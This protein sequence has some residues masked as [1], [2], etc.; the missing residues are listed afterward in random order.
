MP[1]NR[2]IIHL[3][4]IGIKHGTSRSRI[5]IVPLLCILLLVCFCCI[6]SNQLLFPP[7]PPS[8]PSNDQIVGGLNRFLILNRLCLQM[9]STRH[10][11]LF[12]DYINRGLILYRF[13]V[14]ITFWS[15][16]GPVFWSYMAIWLGEV[17]ANYRQVLTIYHP[18]Q[19]WKTCA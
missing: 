5:Y 14:S 12:I 19:R 10:P 4:Q 8:P 18:G 15:E 9:E 11:V 1:G 13:I 2:F 7:S 16:F 6:C 3:S 17:T